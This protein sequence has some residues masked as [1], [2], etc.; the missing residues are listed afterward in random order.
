MVKT[1]RRRRYTLEAADAARMTSNLLRE[2]KVTLRHHFTRDAKSHDNQPAAVHG[3]LP[4]RRDTE[5]TRCEGYL[6]G[7]TSRGV[8]NPRRLIGSFRS[9]DVWKLARF[10][11]ADRQRTIPG[12]KSCASRKYRTRRGLPWIGALASTFGDYERTLRECSRRTDGKPSLTEK[13]LPSDLPAN[14]TA[15]S[16]EPLMKCV[17]PPNLSI[18]R[19]WG[20][21]TS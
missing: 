5:P 13:G 17:I 1:S 20:R 15:W 8:G 6:T 3:F 14:I 19:L 4:S 10:A 16:C 7:L 18:M 12:M 21:K 11:I 9:R 2:P